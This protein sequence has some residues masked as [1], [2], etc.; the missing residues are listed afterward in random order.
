M[1]NRPNFR[2]IA[3]G[4]LV[5]SLVQAAS[6]RAEEAKAAPAT[7]VPCAG[8]E[9][10]QLDF[11]VGTWDATWPA[12]PGTPAGKG[13]NRI[14][15][16]LGGCVISENFEADGSSPLVG[17]SY[18]T[19][20]ARSKTWQQTWVDNQGSYLALAGDLSDPAGKI[21]AMDSTAPNGKPVKLRMIFKNIAADSFDW[22]WERSLDG[23]ATW[24]VQWPIRYTRKK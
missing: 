17:K 10:R 21:L 12:S 13:T 11:W 20:S 18:S 4:V 7:P 14:E 6:V 19:Y 24:Q 5:L 2:S 3:A 9:F 23:G 16:I 22:S 15:K 8:P 1:R